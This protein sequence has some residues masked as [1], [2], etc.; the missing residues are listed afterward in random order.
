MLY[1][2][3]TNFD[4]FGPILSLAKFGHIPLTRSRQHSPEFGHCLANL[5]RNWGEVQRAFDIGHM[6]TRCKRTRWRW[7]G[8]SPEHTTAIDSDR[9]PAAN[10]SAP[11]GA[12]GLSMIPSFRRSS[13]DLKNLRKG[14]GPL[15]RWK[16]LGNT[17]VNF[18]AIC[19][20]SPGP[21]EP[22]GAARGCERERPRVVSSGVVANVGSASRVNP[23]A[24]RTSTVR[25][26]MGHARSPQRGSARS[27]PRDGPGRPGIGCAPTGATHGFC[28]GPVLA[29]HRYCSGAA[30]ALRWHCT[31]GTDLLLHRYDTL[32]WYCAATTQLLYSEC[33]TYALLTLLWYCAGT[34]L[35]LHSLLHW[36]CSGVSLVLFSGAVLAL[37]WYHTGGT[38]PLHG[39]HMYSGTTQVQCKC[40]SGTALPPHWICN[41][42]SLVRHWYSVG[43]PLGL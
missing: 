16:V 39:F 6:A 40:C 28:D 11:C 32:Y 9:P 17:G 1:R 7:H 37:G 43:T 19:A 10:P 8:H 30:L 24:Q 3:R 35:E 38:Q 41:G 31:A 26:R 42:A 27:A 36:S 12:A 18:W 14:T 25:G 15:T 20:A 21:R 22:E 2:I 13:A 23:S 5:G 4:E 33:C 29:L 34:A